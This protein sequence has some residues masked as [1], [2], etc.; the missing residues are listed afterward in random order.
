MNNFHLNMKVSKFFFS[1][2]FIKE[3]R[4]LYFQLSSP[5]PIQ[6]K[7]LDKELVYFRDQDLA[8][9]ELYSQPC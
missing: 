1:L 5:L 7:K 6:F 4:K 8:Q 9:K 3:F 2:L